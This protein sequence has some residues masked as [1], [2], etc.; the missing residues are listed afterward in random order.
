MKGY[1][2][3]PGL[4]LTILRQLGFD[5]MA[6][7]PTMYFSSM[8]PATNIDSD[9]AVWEVELGSAGI[10]PFV[11][12]GSPAP[13]VGID[14]YTS[15]RAKV[16]YWKEK[17][18]LDEVF[19][20]NLRQVGTFQGDKAA[21][22]LG[23]MLQKL[24]W[25]SMRR[26][27][28]MCAKAIIDG[29]F[30][31]TAV[32]GANFT[33]SYGRPA[34]NTMTLV[35]NRKWGTGEERNPVEDIFDVRD[36]M[37]TMYGIQV[38]N[39][40][41]NSNTLK[42]LILDTSIQNLLMKSS[43]GNGDLFARPATVLGNLFGFGTIQIVDDMYD[44]NAWVVNV[45]GTSITVDNATDFEVGGKLF[46][47]KADET[48]RSEYRTITAVNR[49]TNV[50]TIDSAFTNAPVAGRDK[51]VMQRKYMDDDTVSFSNPSFNGVPAN[52]FLQAPFGIPAHFGMFT[53]REEE[54][55]P[56][57]V[58]LRVQDKG[59]PVLYNPQATYT[60]HV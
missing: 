16:A 50:I 23:R 3:I 13:R 55:D 34:Q 1:D 38:T 43:F 22:W 36:F 25:R 30:T 52:E 42:K 8:F 59:L 11:A 29:G 57:G 20:N 28:W 39:M 7:A 51:V 9:E 32:G 41:M 47:E 26:K 45:S 33:V 10:S 44:M 2:N 24:I 14:G 4:H 53:D 40:A 5:Y 17:A 19:L 46:P 54:W 31:Y 49:S 48:Y 27:E 21:K 35:T 18:F 15:G 37:S 12:P 58:Y 56:D 60:L 6:K